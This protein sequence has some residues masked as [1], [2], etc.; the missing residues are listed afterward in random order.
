MTD[1]DVDRC[2]GLAWPERRWPW[3]TRP[4]SSLTAGIRLDTELA[5]PFGTLLT[6]TKE[7]AGDASGLL[8]SSS[9]SSALTQSICLSKDTLVVSEVPKRKTIQQLDRLDS[10]WLQGSPAFEPSPPLVFDEGFEVVENPSRRSRTALTEK[11]VEAIRTAR[12]GGE[13]IMSIAKRFEVSR[14]TVWEKTR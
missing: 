6:K 11:E 4:M 13:S 7:S 5:E 2:V 9:N 8:Q 3:L 1:T 12:V 10:A 14:M